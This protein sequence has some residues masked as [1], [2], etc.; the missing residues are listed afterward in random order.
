MNQQPPFSPDVR[1]LGIV[2]VEQT[3]G[4]VATPLPFSQSLLLI[5]P[6]VTALIAA[7]LICFAIAYWLFMRQ[8]I[9]AE[10]VRKQVVSVDGAE[11]MC[12]PNSVSY[13]SDVKNVLPNRVRSFWGRAFSFFGCDKTVTTLVAKW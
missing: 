5:W 12:A 8:E 11:E 1:T 4:A 7:T 3:A 10:W 2:T 6:Q 13:R 9:R